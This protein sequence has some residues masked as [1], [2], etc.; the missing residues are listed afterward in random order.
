MKHTTVATRQLLTDHFGKRIAA[1]LD[2]S[3]ASVHPDI[4][5]RL[6]IARQLAL[7]RRRIVILQSTAAMHTQ[8]GTGQ[9]AWGGGWK[10]R[11]A[12]VLSLL[13]LL[14]GLLTISEL[15]DEQRAH[16]LADVDTELLADELPP[17]AY[18]DP[19]FARFLQL[20][21]RN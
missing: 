6:R 8:A 14:G 4:A 2:H 7:A 13:A 15:G 1:Q 18:V 9:L 12:S 20:K 17:A 5:E 10:T 3:V 11:L 21:E 19:G 16:E